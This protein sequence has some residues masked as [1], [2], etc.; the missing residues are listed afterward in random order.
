MKFLPAITL[1][2]CLLMSCG[3]PNLDDPATLDKILA[4]AMVWDSLQK[5]GKEGEELY[6]APNQ[7]TP[8][9]GWAKKMYENGQVSFLLQLAEGL[10]NGLLNEWHEN[11]QKRLEVNL[12]NG[13]RQGLEIEWY[14]SGQKF[15]EV[16]I[17]DGQLDGLCI[18]WYKNG[19][20][21][22]E[23]TYKRGLPITAES[24]KPNGEKC[25]ETN[26]SNGHGTV[27]FY[28]DNG[29]VKGKFKFKDGE[30]VK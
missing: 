22:I 11:G 7:Q 27:V 9:T 29:S 4:E 18:N 5:R 26:L 19:Q 23:G 24:W 12:V 25:S 10:Q 8:F 1:M 13:L 3:S 21:M 15:T 16:N 28:Q 20:K 17:V 30:R 6:Y 14:K 2:T